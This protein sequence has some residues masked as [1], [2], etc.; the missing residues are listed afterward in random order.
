METFISLL[1]GSAISWLALW[2]YYQKAAEDLQKEAAALRDLSARML[3][4]L[5]GVPSFA[6]REPSAPSA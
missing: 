3:E 5:Q 6:G 1:F 2:W 4:R